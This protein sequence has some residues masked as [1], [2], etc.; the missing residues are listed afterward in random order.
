MADNLDL[1]DMP[2]SVMFNDEDGN[3]VPLFITTEWQEFFRVLFNRAG[4]TITQNLDDAVIDIIAGTYNIKSQKNQLDGIVYDPIEVADIDNPTELNTYAGTKP[5]SIIIVTEADANS[6]EFTLYVWDN[7]NAAG[8]DSPFVLAGS[9]GFWIAI[10]GKYNNN[11]SII[12]S[13][14]ARYWGLENVDGS[15]RIQVVGTHLRAEVRVAGVW[16]DAGGF[17]HP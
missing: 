16:K 9:S 1:P 13:D 12:P 5:G 3:P 2:T 4:G 7:A 10:G 8:A 15:W 6:N 11:D 14:K 17:R